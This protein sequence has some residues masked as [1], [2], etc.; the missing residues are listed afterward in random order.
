VATARRHY[1]ILE[2]VERADGATA[3]QALAHHIATIVDLGPA[4]FTHGEQ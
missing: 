2:A 1:T 4:V 3:A